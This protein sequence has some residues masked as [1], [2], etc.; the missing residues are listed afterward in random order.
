M[1]VLLLLS[2]ADGICLIDA[3]TTGG[4]AVLQKLYEFNQSDCESAI[5]QMIKY[6]ISCTPTLYKRIYLAA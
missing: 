6:K 2:N 5:I 3:I 1:T 4:I